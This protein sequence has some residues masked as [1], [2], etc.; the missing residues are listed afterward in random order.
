MK[1]C[2]AKHGMRNGIFIGRIPLFRVKSLTTE[3]HRWQGELG[4]ESPLVV[5]NPQDPRW[6]PS[7]RP[8]PMEKGKGK[9]K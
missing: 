7:Q 9:E 5:P 6:D 1:K 2:Y 3:M 8:P 4:D